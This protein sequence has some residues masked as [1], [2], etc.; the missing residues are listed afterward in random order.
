MNL[1]TAQET[2][3]NYASETKADKRKYSSSISN[4]M[5][6]NKVRPA[7]EHHTLGRKRNLLQIRW[8]NLV[9]D[10]NTIYIRLIFVLY[11]KN[12]TLAGNMFL[13]FI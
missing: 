11:L 10:K 3:E 5:K 13:Y 1:L 8:R 12:K 9:R 6:K 4:I 2:S 7:L